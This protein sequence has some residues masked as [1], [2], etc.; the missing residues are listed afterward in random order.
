ML[1]MFGLMDKRSSTVYIAHQVVYKYF[2]TMTDVAEKEETYLKASRM[3]TV[4][5]EIANCRCIQLLRK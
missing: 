4:G 2:S 1:P 5:M 3:I